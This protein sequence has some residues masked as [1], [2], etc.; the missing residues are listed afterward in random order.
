MTFRLSAP[1]ELGGR[2]GQ[3]DSGAGIL[4][5]AQAPDASFSMEP[6]RA[7][8]VVGV[9]SLWAFADSLGMIM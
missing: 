6:A 2:S 5:G 1:D 9:G 4:V 3:N 8:S 7:Q